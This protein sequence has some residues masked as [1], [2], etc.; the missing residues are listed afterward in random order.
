[1]IHPAILGIIGHYFPLDSGSHLSIAIDEA[2]GEEDVD[3]FDAG[4][5]LGIRGEDL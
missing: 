5:I 3:P 2:G 1:L 4:A